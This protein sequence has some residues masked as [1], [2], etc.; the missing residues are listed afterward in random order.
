MRPI[1]EFALLAMKFECEVT[2]IKEDQRVDGRSVLELMTLGAA[3][4]TELIVETSG[5]D[6]NE[7]LPA[8]V[9]V[10]THIDECSTGEPDGEAE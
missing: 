5:S 3:Q 8:L 10:M 9:A 4:G 6:A 7:A 2:V 1:R